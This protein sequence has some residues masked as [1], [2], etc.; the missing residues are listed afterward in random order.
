[1]R[2]GSHYGNVKSP[3]TS[4]GKLFQ[5]FL[6]LCVLNLDIRIDRNRSEGG[7]HDGI[8]EGPSPGSS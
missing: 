3:E 2:P 7:R 4:D 1:M 5:P 6:D 8:V